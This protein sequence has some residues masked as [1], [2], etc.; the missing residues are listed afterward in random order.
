MRPLSSMAEATSRMRSVPTFPAPAARQRSTPLRLSWPAVG[1]PDPHLLVPLA[2]FA[3]AW[4]LL[5][6]FRGDQWFAGLLFAREGGRWSLG[7]HVVTET[8]VHRGGRLVGAAAWLAVVAM[9]AVACMQSR[10]RERRGPLLALLLSVLGSCLLVAL[11]KRTTGMDCPW[12][13]AGYGGSRPFIPLFAPRPDG[14]PASGCFP[15]GHAG[16]GYAWVAL[17]FFFMR[18][19]PRLRWRGLAVGLG[20]GLLFG[21]SQQLR[22]A[23]FMSHDIAALALCWVVSLSI[24]RTFIALRRPPHVPGRHGARTP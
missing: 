21:I 9:F 16:A 1:R 19:R 8:L 22:G 15:S 2:A 3:I 7:G 13:L 12:D 24:H 11:L 14:L 6:T 18:V 20:A 4:T 10:W 23:H 17:Y 5:V